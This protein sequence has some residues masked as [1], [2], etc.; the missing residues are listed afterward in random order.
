MSIA[1][2]DQP[3]GAGPPCWNAIG[4]TG[5]RSC[6]ELAEFIHCRNCPVF[7]AAARTFLDR[8][9]PD[10]YLA[11]WSSLLDGSDAD[12]RESDFEAARDGIGVV[13][14]RLGAE[15]LALRAQAVVEVTA[16]RPVHRIPHR[17]TPVLA[18]LANL[19]GQLHLC[20]SLHDL[21]G[22]VPSGDAPD[23]AR[24]TPRMVVIRQGS[25]SWVF[26][27]EDVL[28][29]PRVPPALMRNVPS[30]LANPIV[31]FSEAV[32]AWDGRSVG[33]LDEGRVFAALRSLGQ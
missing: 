31:S 3:S 2:L 27:A 23:E 11:E 18:G 20:A 29:V 30:T 17:T 1:V 15:W 14:F 10:D 16:V 12:S 9:A 19:R 5:D 32:F 8:P 13:I 24:R 25:E 28:G 6:P 26:T 33:L 21:L 22:V 7:A 4:V